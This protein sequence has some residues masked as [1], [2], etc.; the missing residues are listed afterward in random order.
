MIASIIAFVEIVPQ[1]KDRGSK[2]SATEIKIWKKLNSCAL[3]LP[4][5]S[6]CHDNNTRRLNTCQQQGVKNK[7]KGKRLYVPG[8]WQ[9]KQ[10]IVTS[11]SVLKVHYK[12]LDLSFAGY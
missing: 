2:D 6:R 10:R 5:A 8:E 7:S 4:L 12:F 9:N 3:L 1:L 11:V